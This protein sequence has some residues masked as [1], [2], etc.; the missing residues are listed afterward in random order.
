M[1]SDLEP[2]AA[3]GRVNGDP[4]HYVVMG[5]D[6]GTYWAH[7]YKHGEYW[8]PGPGVAYSVESARGMGDEELCRI[9][10]CAELEAHGE[11][12]AAGLCFRVQ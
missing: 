12:E 7:I 8:S 1:W 6:F 2:V 5:S 11:R 3:G 4:Y 10:A 9:R